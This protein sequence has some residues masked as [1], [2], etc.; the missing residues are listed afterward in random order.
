[1]S[2]LTLLMVHELN[3]MRK[4][5]FGRI[6]VGEFGLKGSAPHGAVLEQPTGPRLLMPPT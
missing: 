1:M 3:L 6:A 4:H 2:L 5:G